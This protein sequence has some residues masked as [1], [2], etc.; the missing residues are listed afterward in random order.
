MTRGPKPKP[1][2]VKR[3]EGNPG[4][5][6]L[7]E[8]EPEPIADDVDCPEWLDADARAEWSRVYQRLVSCRILTPLDMAILADYCQSYAQMVRA[9]T[10]IQ[11]Y[12]DIIKTP[13]GYV[14]QAPHVGI[15]NQASKRMK[16]AAAELGLTPSSRTRIQV[17]DGGGDEL[18]S[19]LGSN[20]N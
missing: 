6:A 18:E 19:M 17:R 8:F 1:T 3:M 14:Q 5:R 11:K 20:P 2:A 9:E 4:K 16:Q 15:Y 13:S 7:N 10:N 12:G